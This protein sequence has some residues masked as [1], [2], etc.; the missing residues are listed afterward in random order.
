MKEQLENIIDSPVLI[1]QKRK[2]YVVN[3]FGEKSSQSKVDINKIYRYYK[4]LINLLQLNFSD[5]ESIRLANKLIALKILQYKSNFS[6]NYLL[7]NKDNFF[8]IISIFLNKIHFSYLLEYF[9]DLS[10]LPINIIKMSFKQIEKMELFHFVDDDNH[11]VN[12]I[13]G[14]IFEKH[15]NK[16]ELGAYYTSKETTDYI[17]EK[18]IVSYLINDDYSPEETINNKFLFKYLKH[19]PKEQTL[20]KLR[21]IKILDPTCGSGAFLFSAYSIL[22]K[23]YKIL[24]GNYNRKELF[25]YIFKNNLYGIDIDDEAIELLR[26]RIII[27]SIQHKDSNFIDLFENFVI[28]NTLVGSIDIKT[29]KSS[30]EENKSFYTL[31]NSGKLFPTETQKE[32]ISKIKPLHL[33]IIYKDILNNGGFDCIIGNPP[34]VENNKIFYKLSDYYSIKSGNLYAYV[35]ERS[36]K[37]LKNKGFIGM[38][39]PI[40]FISTPRMKYIRE[41]CNNNLDFQFISSFADRPS[42][43][44]LGVHQKLNII[45]GRKNTNQTKPRIFTSSY[46]HWNKSNSHLL[47]DNIQYIKNNI[48]AGNQFY[49]KVGNK[50]EESIISKILKRTHKNII[51]NTDKHGNYS[52]YLNMRLLFWNKSFFEEQKSK[53]YKK[54]SFHKVSFAKIFYSLTNSNLFFFFWEMVSDGWHITNKDLSSFRI[55]FNDF[56]DDIVN[57]LD[58]INKELILNLE[59]NKKEINTKQTNFE[60]QHKKAKA[61]IDK[62]DNIFANYYFLS[63]EEINYLKY[64][65]IKYRMNSELKN[66]LNKEKYEYI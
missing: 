50:I 48:D 24:S 15:I 25:H 43:L 49:Y 63:K 56:T 53:E 54:F 52:V 42:S 28:G 23:T 60:Y 4:N 59:T 47:F 21:K 6:I 18:T 5:T 65:N 16:K 3:L 62:Y 44:F 13:L 51:D 31:E 45:I 10:I 66:Y 46:L 19:Q 12:D 7:I 11:T 39:I 17:V 14:A 29:T 9:R 2:P 58:N 64:Y 8:S 61:I 40:S 41:F 1:Q 33:S 22:L 35:L 57:E 37:L 30:N 36:I 34:Y 26:F 38:I 32:W 55:D 20:N 27:E